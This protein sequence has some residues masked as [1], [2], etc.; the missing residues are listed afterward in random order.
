MLLLKVKTKHF[1]TA[2]VFKNHISCA[3]TLAAE[4]R[5]CKHSGLLIHHAVSLGEV[6]DLLILYDEGT[7]FY[8]KCLEPHTQHYIVTSQK[9]QFLSS[10]AVRT[11]HFSGLDLPWAF[12]NWMFRVDN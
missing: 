3:K 5:L 8:L 9:T 11:S 10:I 6:L 1:Y 7:V 12:L 4:L 2:I